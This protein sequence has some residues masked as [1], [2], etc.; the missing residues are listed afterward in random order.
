MKSRIETFNDR[1]PLVGPAFWVASAQY[2]LIQFIVALDWARPYSLSKNTIS[3]L[4]NTA[5]GLYN[6]RAVC[7][8]LHNVMNASFILLGLTMIAGSV[9]IYR[10]FK[11]G[12]P[13]ITGFTFMA[14]AGLGTLL[15]GLFPENTISALHVTGATLPFFIGNLGMVILGISLVIPKSLRIYTILSG[16]ISLAAFGLFTTHNYLGLGEGGM[17]RLTAYPQTI[18]LIVFGLYMSRSHYRQLKG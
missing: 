15:V 10:E 16:L 14:F 11:Q 1:Y 8:P 2:F 12:R 7:S 6:G 9:L 5:C 17:E 13:A 3:D 18:W 4:G